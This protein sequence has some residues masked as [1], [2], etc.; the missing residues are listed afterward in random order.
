MRLWITAPPNGA[1]PRDDAIGA[2]HIHSGALSWSAL[3]WSALSWNVRISV[4]AGWSTLVVDD[5]QTLSLGDRIVLDRWNHPLGKGGAP[6]CILW[7]HRFQRFGRFKSDREIE[8][9]LEFEQED[10]MN[11]QMPPSGSEAKWTLSH[12]IE[13]DD[14]RGMNVAV[15]VEVGSLKMTV[16]E[17]LG[18]VPGKVIKLDREVGPE[19]NIYVGDKPFGTGVLVDVDGFMAVEIKELRK[20]P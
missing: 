10:P 8:L 5:I 17:A 15:R 16:E 18:L 2:R 1:A 9:K 14:A 11:E 20:R 7:N 19:V 13:E 4:C 3:S 12:E 6:S